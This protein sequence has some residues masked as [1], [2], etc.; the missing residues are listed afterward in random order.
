VV[1]EVA[2]D[3][4]ADHQIPRL[5]LQRLPAHLE[6]PRRPKVIVTAPF[7]SPPRISYRCVKAG[8]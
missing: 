6:G 8:E 1:R 4:V 5:L 2:E 7:K 3:G